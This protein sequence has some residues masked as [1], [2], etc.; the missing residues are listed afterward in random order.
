MEYGHERLLVLNPGSTSTKLALF[1]GERQQLKSELLIDENKYKTS[2]VLEQY[3][4]RMA[5]VG[6]F[7]EANEIDPAALD[8]V[9]TRGPALWG[10]R[11][12]AYAIDG[13]LT[14]VLRYAPRVQHAASVGS[15]IAYELSQKYGMPALFY[16][17][18]S[19]DEAEEILHYTGIPGVRRAVTCH[20]LNTKM[21]GRQVAASMGRKYEDCTFIIAHLGGGIT[22]GL[23]QEG[24]I[25]DTLSD[26]EGSMSPQRAGR[27][28]TKY[29]I[30]LC[31]SGKY[32]K[33]ELT[34]MTRGKGG[35]AG[36]NQVPPVLQRPPPWKGGQGLP[37]QEDGVARGAPLKPF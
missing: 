8:A 5:S 9:V 33:E 16:D 35:I 31:C 12:G 28:G 17:S 3:E 6:A 26:D 37:P 22:V 7:L 4:D 30:E 18:A 32:T 10:L 20:C 1:E 27:I 36:E 25:V 13:H 15:F 21:V 29:M 19:A 11:S 34:R 24:R 2:I 23:H 14:T